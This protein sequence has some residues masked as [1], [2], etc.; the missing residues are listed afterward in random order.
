MS[1]L[2]F[3]RTFDILPI[4]KDKYD[5]KVALANKLPDGT[6][7]KYSTDDFIRHVNLISQSLLE[8]GYKKGDKIANISYNRPEWNFV[9]MA[10]AQT[11]MVHV[12]LYPT[13]S[14]EELIYILNDS[15]SKV[16]FA[17]SA[18][19]AEKINSVKDKVP[20]LKDIFTYHKIQGFNHWKELLTE[21]NE[22]AQNKIREIKKDIDPQDLLTIIYTSG[23]TGVSKGVMLTH[24]NLVSNVK[25][26]MPLMPIDN[27]HTVLSFLP[28][29]HVFERMV[30]YLYMYAG[31]SIYYA[32]SLETI[33][34]NLKEVR[35]HLFT[36]VPR[37]LEKVYDKIYAKGQDLTGVKRKLF[38][39]A[40]NLGLKYEHHG[41]N[42]LWYEIQLT[43]AN[44]LIFSK[45]REAL[46]NRVIGIVSGGAALQPRLARVFWAA[47]IPV[48]E[49]YG[50]TETSP[51]VAVNQFNPRFCRFGTVGPV[52]ENVEVKIAEDGEILVKGP[53]VMQA[54]YKKPE[55]TEEVIDKDGYFH[56][57]D[58]GE[59][60][61]DNFLK[62]TDRKKEIFKTSG[63]KYI[64]PQPMENKFKESPFI[65][66]IMVT[67]EN[68]KFP[69]ALIS[70]AMQHLKEWCK[71]KKIEFQNN[72]D[73]LKNPEVIE[74]Y[75][76]EIDKYNESFS[77]WEKIKK[78]V[79]LDAEW[80]IDSGELTH[81]QKLKRK[82]ILEKY[83]DEFERMYAG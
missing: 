20:E 52:L 79:I 77:D 60:D 32:E 45:W 6:W 33:A 17:E 7:K 13:L 48:V 67:G 68:K 23:T 81:T 72:A 9:D 36:T 63:G 58:I 28:L 56:T 31:L 29:S 19:L 2:K 27:R 37:L 66:Q 1:N 47:K 46:G 34:D 24:N 15:E 71:I 30:V 43:L 50:L 76:S 53:N 55:L 42:G 25:A 57:G 4:Q 65:E 10:T 35:P 80:S 21:E 14:K 11:G 74:K 54:Y 64:A 69:S 39:W 18:E 22:D 49:G 82:V 75:K 62:I 3:Q 51:V 12:P 41:K 61:K 5:K 44:K 16:I 59:L 26:S 8:R 38:F 73:L 70:P 78:F 40:L 83:K